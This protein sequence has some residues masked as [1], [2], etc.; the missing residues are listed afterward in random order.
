MKKAFLLIILLAFFQSGF[1][2]VNT[3]TALKA[4]TLPVFDGDSIDNIWR[5][6]EWKNIDQVW[7]PYNNI[8]P[9][10]FTTE[11][12]TK[13]ISGVADFSGRYKMLWSEADSLVLFLVEIHDDV[14]I[15]GYVPNA[16][17]YPNYDVIEVF[18]DEN[19]SGGNHLFD[20]GGNNAENAFSYH[21]N[22]NAPTV[23]GVTT[24]LTGAMDIY[25]NSYS[26]IINYKS[27]FPMY[28]MKNYGGGRYVY[29]FAMRIYKDTYDNSDPFASRRALSANDNMG[30]TIAYCD[31]D[32]NDNMRNHFIGS[33]TVSGPNNNNSYIDAS[34]FGTLILNDPNYVAPDIIAPSIPTNLTITNYT[35]SWSAST[36]NISV[37]GYNLYQDYIFLTSLTGL[38]YALP[39]YTPTGGPYTY[40][41]Q[42]FDISGN[43]STFSGSIDYTPS[44]PDLIVMYGTI[45]G[46]CLASDFTVSGNNIIDTVYVDAEA[47]GCASLI[48]Y[49]SSVLGHD[50]YMKIVPQNFTVTPVIFSLAI[51]VRA[52]E[53]C[54]RANFPIYVSS[55]Y[56]DTDTLCLALC[57]GGISKVEEESRINFYP[58]PVKDILNINLQKSA[59]INITNVLGNTVF[60]KSLSEG[61][62]TID[63]SNLKKGYYL[64]NIEQPNQS[65]FVKPLIKE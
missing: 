58:N 52:S 53:N 44:K 65:K 26:D 22:V 50:R 47:L 63:I 13:T 38:T 60:S 1:T 29:E 19:H 49:S 40:K 14:F 39:G 43:L 9:S 33:V 51:C 32:E 31:N 34:I 37:G 16:S 45:A 36:D 41:V 10:A 15:D 24:S 42:A 25:G 5:S 55:K 21:M 7:I 11:S 12:G 6:A 35:L 3:Y 62:Q 48:T 54:E 56:A 18:I 2:Q 46:G 28:S 20:S 59:T 64:L 8:L 17:N 23:G 4:S 27:H 30:F 61:Q 57:V